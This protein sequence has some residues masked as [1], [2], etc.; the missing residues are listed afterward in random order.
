MV[1]Y[2]KESTKACVLKPDLVGEKKKKIAG[3]FLGENYVG[4]FC[5][6]SVIMR[7]KLRQMKIHNSGQRGI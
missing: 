6:Y 1:T 4:K 5:P 3:H 7:E 2:Q